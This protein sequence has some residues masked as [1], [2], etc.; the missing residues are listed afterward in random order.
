MY[1]FR[2][3]WHKVCTLKRTMSIYFHYDWPN[4]LTKEKKLFIYFIQ[5][6]KTLGISIIMFVYCIVLVRG[7]AVILYT[8]TPHCVIINYVVWRVSSWTFFQVLL[9]GIL[10]TKYLHWTRQWIANKKKLCSFLQSRRFQ[11]I[12]YSMYIGSIHHLSSMCA[13]TYLGSI[14]VGIPHLLGA[15]NVDRPGFDYPTESH[16][17][18]P[19]AVI[20]LTS[21]RV[22]TRDPMRL[23]IQCIQLCH[24]ILSFSGD[25]TPI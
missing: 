21:A 5:R 7:S 6:W 13:V 1:R 19:Y 4:N 10:Y 8:T 18:R 2:T 20:N 3:S 15:V 25:C 24:R 23:K 22:W 17:T 9:F 14:V 16:L 11:L 12:L